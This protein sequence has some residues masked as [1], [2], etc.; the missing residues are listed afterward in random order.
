M[1]HFLLF[2]SHHSSGA[3]SYGTG[4]IGGSQVATVTGQVNI[5]HAPP[6]VSTVR[7]LLI[8]IYL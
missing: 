8:F 6:S 7:K 4:H 3:K 1:T 5:G 2:F